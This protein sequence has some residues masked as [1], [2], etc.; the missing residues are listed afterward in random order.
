MSN[1]IRT[2]GW[3]SV[4]SRRTICGDGRRE[5]SRFLYCPFRGAS[6]PTGECRPCDWRDGVTNGPSGDAVLCQRALA[7]AMVPGEAD[8]ADRI[9]AEGEA[10]L[11]WFDLQLP[12]SSL[13]NR[14]V[15][16]V[17]PEVAR[18]LLETL[19]TEREL[20]AVPVVDP[21]GRPLGIVTKTDLLR[22]PPPF[23]RASAADLMSSDVVAFS[24]NTTLAYAAGAMAL[25][26]IQRAPVLDASGS[27]VGILSAS[28]LLRTMGRW[29]GFVPPTG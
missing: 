13:M 17:R 1:T 23:P 4:S 10:G 2:A 6:V 21:A 24:E 16:C 11:R 7:E 12:V 19:L 18:E 28:D 3:L 20:G 29:A 27:V 9:P 22:H 8:P 14:S 15:V 5:I 25:E 26:A